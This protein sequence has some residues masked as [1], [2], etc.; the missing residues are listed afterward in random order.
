MAKPAPGTVLHLPD[1][2]DGNPYQDLLA[3]GLAQAGWDSRFADYQEGLLLPLQGVLRNHPKPQVLHLHWIA[4]YLRHIFWSRSGAVALIKCLLLALDILLARAR[5]VRV[6]W[7][8]HNL[9]CHES[10]DPRREMLAR[11]LMALAASRLICHSA[12]ALDQVAAALALPIRHKARVIPHGH[13]I[14]IYDNSAA[15]TA[16]WRERLGLTDDDIVVLFFGA[17]RD[18]KGL[19]HLLEAFHQTGTPSLKLVIAGRPQSAALREALEHA[20]GRDPR[21]RLHLAQVPVEQVAPLF[22]LASIIAIPFKRTLSSGSALLAMSLGKP[23]LLSEQG[24]V[25]DVVDGQGGLF[26]SDTAHLAALLDGLPLGDLPG[27]GQHNLARARQ[28]DWADIGRAT[29]AAYRG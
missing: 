10:P 23:L 27:M 17:L 1:W 19:Q 8:W 2:R 6:V 12:S 24:R 7:T 28:L 14:G 4:P 15:A 29:A 21:I 20:A 25:L 18:Y 26:F 3:G 13:Y 16:A 9:V 5:G 11:R 22:S